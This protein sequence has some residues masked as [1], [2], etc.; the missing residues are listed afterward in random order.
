MKNLLSINDLSVSDVKDIF[1]TVSSSY[2]NK[3]TTN[4]IMVNLFF[5]PSTRTRV[6]FEIAAL[7]LGMQVV[8]VVVNNSSIE[9]GE[10]IEDTIININAM[11]PDLLVIRSPESYIIDSLLPL[12]DCPIINAGDGTN[13][14][15]TQALIDAYIIDEFKSTGRNLEGCTVAICG[16]IANSR[17]ARSNIYLL[18][19]LGARLRLIAPKE[20]LSNNYKGIKVY[21][22]LD[23]ETLYNCDAII[24]LRYPKEYI[25]I[26]NH[27]EGLFKDFKLNFPHD[28]IVLHP[29]PI[30]PELGEKTSRWYINE[31]R[32]IAVPMRMAIIEKM[33]NDRD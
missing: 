4:K 19:K 20:V 7:R 11:K 6:S 16:D 2:N 9:K 8:N 10:S 17:V 3:T 1:S 22:S 31:Q 13:E 33:L 27:R 21:N 5:E 28:I 25:A 15:P 29:G 24:M 26:N 23:N 14:H 12:I 30:G 18:K 32:K